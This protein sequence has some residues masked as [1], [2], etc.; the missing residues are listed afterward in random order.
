MKKHIPQW[1]VTMA[2]LLFCAALSGQGSTSPW[3]LGLQYGLMNNHG[4]L[5]YR[6]ID[7]NRRL[8]DPLD[9]LDYFSYGFKVE[10]LISNSFGLE[11]SYSDGKFISNDRSIDWRGD[12]LTDNEN[13][14]RS[15]N[16][17]T[18]IR[19]YS[20]SLNIYANNGAILPTDAF[21]S[22][23]LKIGAGITDFD[24]FGDLYHSG[25]QRYYYWS[26]QTIRTEAE[27]SGKQARIIS[28]DGVFETRL[29]PLQTEGR[30]YDTHAFQF[31]T[32]LGLK[33]RLSRRFNLDLQA[34]FRFTQ[35]D[36]LDDVSG[37]F[38]EEYDNQRQAYAS[39]PAG[40]EAE[41]R[42]SPNGHND[43]YSFFS[44]GLNVDLGFRKDAFQPPL[45]YTRSR[46]EML[47]DTPAPA[48]P[49]PVEAADRDLVTEEIAGEEARVRTATGS[50]A[51]VSPERISGDE[52]RDQLREEEMPRTGTGT[53]ATGRSESSIIG[54]ISSRKEEP[55]S[56]TGTGAAA[57]V[58]PD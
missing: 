7:P 50:G 1:L 14:D 31:H 49:V 6:F 18:D 30:D 19:D 29:P 17:L 37:K 41:Y 22:P 43:M 11:A 33:F 28:Q 48:D 2:L 9:N 4:D 23:F 26:D 27:G 32:G 25:G 3:R 47:P 57:T 45:V 12:V 21:L 54:T 10:W 56:A 52:D 40:I 39:N 8:I 38:P 46:E 55:K 51:T 16:A 53:T 36:Y 58:Q 42:G 13:F 35:T 34:V 44:I 20:L 15:L 5:S 24:V